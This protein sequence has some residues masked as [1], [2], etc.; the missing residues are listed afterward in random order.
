MIFLKEMEAVARAPRDVQDL[1]PTHLK[2]GLSSRTDE[3]SG[4]QGH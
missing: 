3:I 1:L 2:I 4:R